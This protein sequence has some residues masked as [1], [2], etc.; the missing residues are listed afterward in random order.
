MS[1]DLDLFTA[2]AE[3]AEGVD[4]R[5]QALGTLAEHRARVIERCRSAMVELWR[6][7]SFDDIDATVSGDDACR[8]LDQNAPQFDYR[9]V[10]AVF[11]PKSGWRYVRTGKSQ[12]K[13]RHARPITFWRWN[14]WG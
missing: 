5:D 1:E 10:G 3:G 11:R 7:R 14:Q 9:L 12:L 6:R 2:A 8:W 4:L 13:R